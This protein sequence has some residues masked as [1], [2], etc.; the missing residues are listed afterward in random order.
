MTDEFNF[1]FDDDDDDNND[2]KVDDNDDWFDGEI[3]DF[4]DNDDDT[5]YY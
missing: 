5:I 1:L 3:L 2:Y 4:T